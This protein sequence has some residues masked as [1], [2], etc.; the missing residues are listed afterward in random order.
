MAKN[1]KH[2]GFIVE[3]PSQSDYPIFVE[4][5]RGT[6]HRK[7]TSRFNKA[8]DKEPP[9]RIPH[10][11]G[12]ILP[13]PD[14]KQQPINTIESL[15]THL[16]KAMAIELAT[17]PLY[18]FA[19]Y[20]VKT[21]QP[22]VRDPRYYDP[23]VGVLAE[24]MLHLSLA[25]NVLLAVGGTPKLYD[26]D[27]VPSYKMLMP[28]RVPELWLE[29]KALT[30][31]HLE[32]FVNVEKREEPD[33]QPEPDE[34]HT[35]GQF[36]DAIIQGLEYLNDK[37]PLF[38]A[39]TA[40]YQ[41]APG[42]GYQAKVRDAGGSVI[43]TNLD[44]AREALNTIV[45]QGEG[46]PGPTKGPFDD[47]SKL[48]KDHYD[49]FL[50]LMT[51]PSTWDVYPVRS[52]PTTVGYWDE[53]RQIYQVSV[54]FDAAYCF[55]L[56]TIE[57]LWTIDNTDSRHKLVLGNMFGIMMGVLAPLA[58]FLVQQEIGDKGEHAAPCFCYYQF[59]DDT[60]A[61]EQVQE[62]MQAAIDC[63]VSVTEETPDQ[64]TVNDFGAMLEA[65]LPIQTSINGLIDLDT[66]EKRER[67][68][69]K[70]ATVVGAQNQGNKG[71]AQGQ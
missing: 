36:Y 35:L 1:W 13:T 34:Y 69:V 16:Q 5:Q 59:A 68:P 56:L 39:D 40:K 66:F 9:L 2:L 47:P 12:I 17:I 38:N 53:S 64:V 71:F 43:V 67:Y 11:G 3:R 45:I 10:G 52:N 4:T 60:S 32:S 41:F 49:I 37:G 27:Y 58:K 29:L 54:A 70:K 31:E 18:L 62:E 14:T 8:S 42:L 28:K 46:S 33:A 22:Y 44:T 15:Q 19:M 50:D 57:K 26:P 7:G 65:L 63:Y 21:P 25:G 24:E 61:L 48:E 55:L 30:K 20:S 51:G 6:I 23:I